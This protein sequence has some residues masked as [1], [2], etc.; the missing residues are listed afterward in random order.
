M[1]ETGHF[2]SILNRLGNV[3]DSNRA[4]VVIQTIRR[5][6][7]DFT[8]RFRTDSAF[9]V[10][11]VISYLIKHHFEFAIKA[12]FWKLLNLKTA[13]QQRKRWFKFNQQW[14][15]FWIKQ[16]IDSI[17]QQ[18]YVIILRKKVHSPKVHYQLKLFSPDD[19]NYEYSAIVT[20]NKNWAPK[21]LLLFV[22][23]RSAQKNSISELKT[24]FA[25]DHIPTNTY[26][27]TVGYR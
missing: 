11:E 7:A 14:G 20:D 8:L 5:Q 15:Y 17:D 12:P 4:L 16:P 26:R 18:H 6:L 1:G 24:S 25:F 23:G 10:S 9:F 13:A 3:H 22:C 21:E 2:L 27:T 19:G